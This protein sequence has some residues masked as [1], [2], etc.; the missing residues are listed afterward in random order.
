M[1]Y[2][3][4]YISDSVK[5]FL[6]KNKSFLDW[7]NILN[8]L[9]YFE[10][11]SDTNIT[12]IYSSPFISVINNIISRGLPTKISYKVEEIISNKIGWS[13]KNVNKKVGDFYYSL[14]DDVL[15]SSENC[16]LLKRAFLVLDPRIK[17]MLDKSSRLKLDL[18]SWEN[19]LG[20]SYEEK[21]Y[22][23]IIPQIFNTHLLLQFI[24]PQKEIDSILKFSKY[25]KEK[26]DSSVLDKNQFYNQ[27]NDFALKLFKTDKTK[28]GLVIEIDGSQHNQEPQN[29]LDKQRDRACRSRNWD[30]LR[31]TTD[32]FNNIP[33]NKINVIKEF[34]LNNK[35]YKYLQKNY[36]NP[37][38]KTTDGLKALQ[39]G[40]TPFGIARIQKTILLLIESEIL[41]LDADTWNIAILER[42]VP[43]GFL[44]ID[45]LKDIIT[46]LNVISDFILQIP[47]INLRIYNTEEFKDCELS[48]IYRTELYSDTAKDIMEY[49]ADVLIDISI[50]QKPRFTEVTTQFLV[51]LGNP[52]IFYIRTSYD[53]TSERVFKTDIPIKYNLILKNNTFLDNPHI[54]YEL[55][56]IKSL[57]YFLQNIFRKENFREGQLEILNI[58]LQRNSVIALLPTGA[59]KSLTYQLAVFLQPGIAIIIDPI[60]SLMKDQVDGLL[61][62][63]ID[64][65]SFINSTLKVQQRIEAMENMSSC[66][67]QFVF[68]SP[69]RLQI[70]EFQEIL[71]QTYSNKN[72]FSYCVIDETHC[73]S[74]WGHDFRVPYLRLGENAIKHCKTGDES[75]IPLLGLTGTASYDVLTDVERELNL[76]KKKESII[77]PYSTERE[78]LIFEVIDSGNDNIDT[79]NH[80]KFQTSVSD[81]KFDKLIQT[82]NELPG[83]FQVDRDT[84]FSLRKEKSFC[85][86]IFCP[87]TKGLFGVK[88]IKNKILAKIPELVGKMAIF[89]GKENDS[90]N[91]KAQNGFKNNDIILLVATKAFGMGIDKPNIRYTVHFTMPPSIESF[92]QEAGRAGRDKEKAFCY[93][94]YSPQEMSNK[95][96][97]FTKDRDIQESFLKSS[98]RGIPRENRI[99]DELLTDIHN[100]PLKRFEIIE[101]ELNDILEYEIRLSPWEKNGNKRLY[102]NQ[103]EY[104]SPSYGYID[105]INTKYFCNNNQYE[106]LLKDIFD[107]IKIKCNNNNGQE[108]YNWINELIETEPQDGIENILSQ[109][110]NIT[111]LNIGF[112]NDFIRKIQNILVSNNIRISLKELKE[113]LHFA[114]D[115]NLFK[116][117]IKLKI[118]HDDLEDYYNKVRLHS[119]TDKSI[120]RLSVPRVIDD[121]TIDYKTSYYTVTVQKKDEDTY[122]NELKKYVERYKPTRI[123]DG[124]EENVNSL[125]D[126]S[127]LRKSLR[128]L[129]KFIYENIQVKRAQAI[130]EMEEA[131]KKGLEFGPE[132]FK[133]YVRT[134]FDSKYYM[135]LSRFLRDDTYT[136]NDIFYYIE[137][138]SKSKDNLEHMRG[139]CGR[140]L[141]DNP[142]IGIFKLLRNYTMILLYGITENNLEEIQ[143][144]FKDGWNNVHEYTKIN[145]KEYID[146]ILKYSKY[147][148]T[149]CNSSED[150]IDN[151]FLRIHLEWLKKYKP[152]NNN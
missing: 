112:E 21:F 83:K 34:V 30:V 79:S 95:D 69:E 23:E 45:D 134:Y 24:Q 37:I 114:E 19:H 142:N 124:V 123:V 111:N 75:I 13:L 56:K 26:Y 145:R 60:K 84:F 110:D 36:D 40:L 57:R 149:N 126:N 10:L 136:M 119:D 58:A 29:S 104:D 61:C 87:H 129:V 80:L 107:Y 71:A 27:K 64:S 43:C 55:N 96:R 151:E 90:E 121:Y 122:I 105:F 97:S 67:Y 94:L 82:I 31:I 22:Y 150:F 147:L 106:S 8:E 101:D 38:Y 39:L 139:A 51:K 76:D 6:F 14:I 68:I 115:Y 7:E 85:G 54:V 78:E 127:I 109:I 135:P 140:L 91:E 15:N 73:V 131:C 46:N 65:S 11:Y 44:A 59:G 81:A 25:E 62:N 103:P 9:S 138:A 66:K 137:E 74:E 89:T 12:S 77:R 152:D 63:S 148:S 47:K 35:Q 1:Q 98:F 72:Y 33:I 102:V 49:R 125:E 32:E 99:L 2:Q 88:D 144:D 143:I 130:N 92:Y 18:Q 3:C 16:E 50:L 128:Y 17:P 113:K 4:G 42:D 28:N 52:H 93:I 117:S 108:M 116:K 53:I 120:Y 48:N 100:C 5:D 146:G 20:S 132:E 70:K 41:K 86:I 141:S 133:S 118:D